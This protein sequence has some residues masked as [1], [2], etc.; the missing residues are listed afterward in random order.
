[1]NTLVKCLM[2]ED[3]QIGIYEMRVE[4]TRDL[5]RNFDALKRIARGILARKSGKE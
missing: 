5:A 4:V 1:M 2:W 3:Q